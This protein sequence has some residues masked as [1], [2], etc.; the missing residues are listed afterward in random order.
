MH[1]GKWNLRKGRREWDLDVDMWG[2]TEH[3][4]GGVARRT[5][6]HAGRR[7]LLSLFNGINAWRQ[8]WSSLEA[9]GQ[10]LYIPN[11][12]GLLHTSSTTEK[13]IS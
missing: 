13:K 7:G 3:F 11:E 12:W 1:A 2:G 5:G 4:G 8:R 6:G 9:P 10:N